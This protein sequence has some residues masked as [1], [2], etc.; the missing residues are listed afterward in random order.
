MITKPVTTVLVMLCMFL[1]GACATTPPTQ[2]M[3]D[4]RQSVQAAVEIG[5]E[6]L[7]PQNLVTAREYLERA[8]RELE[9]RFFSRARQDA[10]IAKNEAIKAHNVTRAIR[11]ARS[12][13]ADSTRSQAD[14]D[15]ADDLLEQARQAAA[16]GRD[17]RAIRLAEEARLIAKGEPAAR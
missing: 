7:A 16:E 6:D 13:I 17:R 12:A 5:A 9:M 10:M 4:A 3:S 2:E 14:R 11:E 1:L 15:K 8:E